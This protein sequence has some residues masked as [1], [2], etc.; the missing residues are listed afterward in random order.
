MTWSVSEVIGALSNTSKKS[1]ASSNEYIDM[2]LFDSVTGIGIGVDGLGQRV[3]VLPGQENVSSFLTKNADF[4]PVCQVSW[5]EKGLELP[6]VATLTCRADFSSPSVL[7]AIAV[8]FLGLIELQEKFKNA[9]RAIWE[10]KELFE[11][12][13]RA[14]YTEETLVGLIG[15]VLVI[16]RLNSP[17]EILRFWHLD[18]NDSFDFSSSNLRLEVKT[19]TNQSRQH[20]FSSNQIGTNQ[21]GK[22][23]VASL[24]LNKVEVGE[25]LGAIVTN[26]CEKLD[27]K[28]IPK[29]L[30]R[31]IG[32]LGCSIAFTNGHRFDADS[33]S[34]SLILIEG[35]EVPKPSPAPGVVYMS[36]TADLSGAPAVEMSLDQLIKRF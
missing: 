36:W 33:T 7:E 13:F 23:I 19:S 31:V 16:N 20:K 12:G 2:K 14:P 6:S 26:V 18:P 4:D 34:D 32:I 35:L 17:S 28:D 1:K 3:L 5:L 24:V 11:N 15:E 10:M 9:G 22:V 8:V 29:F 30:E 27:S 21:D 25:N